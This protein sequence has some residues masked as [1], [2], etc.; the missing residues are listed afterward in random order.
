MGALSAYDVMA[1]SAD[2]S[3]LPLTCWPAAHHP[4]RC[5][6][7]LSRPPA[8]SE[9]ILIM[10]GCGPDGARP[11]EN[12]TTKLSRVQ[13]SSE[14]RTCQ[15]PKVQSRFESG[16]PGRTLTEIYFAVNLNPATKTHVNKHQT[17]RSQRLI[18]FFLSFFLIG[19]M[20]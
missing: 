6:H 9:F 19:I 2:L 11:G 10:A 18:D 13:F 14:R 20:L 15:T 17:P 12:R 16:N 1:W 8:L 5:V 4:L 3:A 7:S